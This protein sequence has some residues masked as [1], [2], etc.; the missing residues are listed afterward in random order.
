MLIEQQ[1]PLFLQQCL[2]ASQPHSVLL[3]KASGNSVPVHP[4]QQGPVTLGAV[5]LCD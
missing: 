1:G 5:W 3:V 4:N 2:P